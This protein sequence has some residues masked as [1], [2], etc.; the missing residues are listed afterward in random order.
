MLDFTVMSTQTLPEFIAKMFP[1]TRKEIKTTLGKMSF[2]DAGDEK[3]RPVFMVHGNPT[4][5]FLYRKV[6]K[7]LANEKFRCIARRI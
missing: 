7:E 2:A 4:W 5:S 6:V 1:C 3:A